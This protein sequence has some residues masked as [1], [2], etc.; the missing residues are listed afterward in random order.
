[1]PTFG[2]IFLK[3]GCYLKSTGAHARDHIE[4]TT[5]SL[6]CARPAFISQV[7]APPNGPAEPI[8]R[9]MNSALHGLDDSRLAEGNLLTHG[10]SAQERLS[11]ARP[12]WAT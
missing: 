5:L 3:C 8:K 6:P 1:M 4:H 12:F 7:Q 9:G 10:A 11:I 2:P